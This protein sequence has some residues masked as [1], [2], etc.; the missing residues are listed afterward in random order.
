MNKTFTLKHFIQLKNESFEYI[1]V[2]KVEEKK[3][4]VTKNRTEKHVQVK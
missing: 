2:I 4:K 3:A 1:S